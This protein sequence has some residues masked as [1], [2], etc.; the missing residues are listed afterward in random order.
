MIPSFFQ[1]S[2][3]FPRLPNGKINKKALLFVTDET[4]EKHE[5]DYDSLS[6]TEKKLISIW[7]TVLKT[8]N[9]NTSKN[10]F[11]NGGTSILAIN[12]ANLISKEF[13]IT[14]KALL[15]FEFPTIKD[16][17]DYLSGKKGDVSSQKNLE[18]DEKIKSKKNVN[19]KRFR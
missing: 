7:E 1:V 6:S 11:E 18:I 10:F 9:I 2:D 12:L 19:F 14:L 17:S 16:Q 5:I 8:K 4:E 13:S 3:G 15:I